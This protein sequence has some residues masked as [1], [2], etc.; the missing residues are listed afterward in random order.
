MLISDAL[1]AWLSY[2]QRLADLDSLAAGTVRNNRK[3]ADVWIGQLGSIDVAEL[4]KSHVEIALATIRGYR[5]AVTVQ[6]DLAL[7]SQ[8]LN[9]CVDEGHLTAKPR[10]PTVSVPHV[11]TELPSDPAFLWVLANTPARTASA[12]EFMLLTGLAPHELERV[13]RGDYVKERLGIGMRPDFHVKAA[14][15]RRWIPLNKRARQLWNAASV[16]AGPE[17]HPFPTVG[18]LEKAIQRSRTRTAPAGVDQI[19]PKMMRKWFASKISGDVAEHVLQRLLGH[20]PGSKITRRHYVRSSAA[21]VE[22][23]VDALEIPELQ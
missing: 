7:L 2:R 15:R 1:R 19:T 3:V 20:S 22:R 21:D 9:W 23:A 10:L 18:A 8:V 14:S 5:S 13:Q 6:A 11:E 12:L 16:M 17:F 4:R